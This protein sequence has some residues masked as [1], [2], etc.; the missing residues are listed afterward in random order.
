MS[1]KAALNW[2]SAVITS[3]LS[4]LC[5]GILNTVLRS[6]LHSELHIVFTV[7]HNFLGCLIMS[8]ERVLHT[9]AVQEHY[10]TVITDTLSL[11]VCGFS[12]S[13]IPRPFPPSSF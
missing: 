4:T 9:V 8:H 2:W 6:E 3:G 7:E 12:V 11:Y 1:V 5:A 13:L 10:I